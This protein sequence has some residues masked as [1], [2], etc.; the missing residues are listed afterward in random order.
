MRLF[1]L[2]IFI[3][4]S[5]FAQEQENKL[6]SAVEYK[7]KINKEWDAEFTQHFRLKEDFNTVDTHIS[8][9]AA[10][11][12]PIKRLKFGGEFRY[13]YRND[14]QGG[15]QGFENML[16]YR[17]NVE[18]KLK[19]KGGNLAFRLGY[20]YRFSLDRENRI[21][22]GFRFRPSYEWKIKDWSLDPKFFFE[23][24]HTYNEEEQ[25]AY[26]YGVGSKLKLAGKTTLNFRY[27]YQKSTENFAADANYHIL[28][29][30]LSASH[31]KKK[32]KEKETSENK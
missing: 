10:Y 17:F 31:P 19:V 28:S 6:W 30:K 27:I 21:K 20:Q 13:L 1:V 12:S 4:I 22:K 14:N 3:G 9:I 5:A 26:R 29:L 15:I 16:R 25:R 8:E 32:K 18:K 11:Y 7:V 2:I 24:F 23:Y